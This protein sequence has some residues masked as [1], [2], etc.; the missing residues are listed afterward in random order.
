SPGFAAMWVR[1][2]SVFAAGE[3]VPGGQRPLLAALAA[4]LIAIGLVRLALAGPAGR[5][6]AWLLSLYLFVP[7]LATWLGALSRP[8]FNE[9]YLVAA[10]PGF[11]L[12]AAAAVGGRKPEACVTGGGGRSASRRLALQG[13]AGASRRLALQGA[14]GALAAAV[15]LAG[16]AALSV[17]SLGR[18]YDD[19]AYSKTRGWRTLAAVLARHATPYATEKVRVAQTYPDPTLWYYYAGAAGHLVL[20]PAAHDAAGADAEVARLVEQG[21]ERVV[22]A[23]QSTAAWDERDIAPAAL[24]KRYA[25]LGETPVAGWRVQ[26]YERPPAVLPARD[27]AFAAGFRLAGA[28]VPAQRV[29]GGDLLSA[30]LRWEGPA[31]AL[32]GSEKL[33]LQLLDA[34]GRLVAQTDRPFTAADLSGQIT[35]DTLIVPRYLVSGAYRLILALYDPAR[36]GAPRLLTAAGA[37][38]VELAVFGM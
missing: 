29:A 9:R 18:Y 30:Y 38:H 21:V 34:Q 28:D 11:Y 2:L 16:L 35:R 20:P 36:P 12:L 22:I 32:S 13:A 17:L 25:L 33:T 37:D 31:G 1:A 3:S 19:P 15:L 27:A 10:L 23:V 24:A 8:I 26:V 14:R 5:R 6:A 7:L 4:G